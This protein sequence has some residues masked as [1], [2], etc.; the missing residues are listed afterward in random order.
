MTAI[1]EA[2]LAREAEL[3][4]AMLAAVTDYDAWHESADAVDARTVFAVLQANVALTQEVV[5]RL[6]RRLPPGG[7]CACGETLDAALVTAP[8]A[9]GEGALARLGPILARRLGLPR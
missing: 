9:I 8:E 7:A 2:K 3:C 1:P 5:R 4:Y 6:V